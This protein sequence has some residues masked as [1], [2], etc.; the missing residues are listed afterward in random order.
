MMKP[1]DYRVQTISVGGY[2]DADGVYVNLRGD[3][4]LGVINPIDE[5]RHGDH[6]DNTSGFG[7]LPYSDEDGDYVPA[8]AGWE[9]QVIET[10]VLY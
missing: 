10:L 8:P 7:V 2:P 3:A 4:Y 5:D 9:A 1:G 6:K